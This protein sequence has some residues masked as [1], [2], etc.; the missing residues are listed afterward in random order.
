MNFYRSAV[1]ISYNNGD[2]VEQ[3][4]VTNGILLGRASAPDMS[5]LMAKIKNKKLS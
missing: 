2:T 4:Q 5:K 3:Q 1:R